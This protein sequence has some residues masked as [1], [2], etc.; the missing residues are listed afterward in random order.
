MVDSEGIRTLLYKKSYKV[1]VVFNFWPISQHILEKLE[2][3][4]LLLHV[5]VSTLNIFINI[6]ND[7]N[8][9]FIYVNVSVS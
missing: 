3:K 5:G 9:F 4:G 8:H 2:G 1:R 6:S 7:G